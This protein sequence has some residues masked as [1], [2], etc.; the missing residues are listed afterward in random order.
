M[1]PE[2]KAVDPRINECLRRA[3]YWLMDTGVDIL[4][5]EEREE[6]EKIKRDDPTQKGYSKIKL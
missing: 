1:A 4:S 6:W 3:D 5:K 2:P